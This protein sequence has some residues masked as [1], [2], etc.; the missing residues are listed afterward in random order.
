M[1]SLA[2]LVEYMRTDSPVPVFAYQFPST[3]RENGVYVTSTGSSPSVAGLATVNIQFMVRDSEI[4]KAE[5]NSLDI[6]K[7]FHKKTNFYVGGLQVVLSESQNVAPIYIGTDGNDNHLF[8]NN[9]V[10]S[11]NEGNVK[12]DK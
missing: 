11:V 10:F 7:L 1:F 12:Y 3:F 5:T 2:S 9:F 8:S 4:N 6:K